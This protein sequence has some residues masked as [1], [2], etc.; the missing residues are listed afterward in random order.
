MKTTVKAKSA[1]LV[2]IV[3]LASMIAAASALGF[4]VPLLVG[5]DNEIIRQ[6]T[7]RRSGSALRLST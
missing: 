6:R 2:A 4:C 1:S 3:L 7:L 5:R